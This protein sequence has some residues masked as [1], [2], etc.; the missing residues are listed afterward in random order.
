M[1]GIILAGGSAKRMGGVRKP[2]QLL[3]GKTLLDRVVEKLNPLFDEL[4]L[5]L[6]VLASIRPFQA[7]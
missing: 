5:S 2:L 4:V 1:A 3:A 7:L 6:I